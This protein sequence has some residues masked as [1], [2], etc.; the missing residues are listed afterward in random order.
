MTINIYDDDNSN[1][2]SKEIKSITPTKKTRGRQKIQMKKIERE[3]DMM[4]TFSKRRLG[5]YKKANELVTLTGCEIGFLV[6]SP[7]GKAFNFAH[8]LCDYIAK[9]YMGQYHNQHQDPFMS[10]DIEAF[11]QARI[12]QLTKRYCL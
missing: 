9:R 8:P 2:N 5:I 1:N 10:Y 6:F 12:E 3:R 4:I 7:T 11:R